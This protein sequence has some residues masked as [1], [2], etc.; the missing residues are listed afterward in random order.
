M[1]FEMS[2]V[3]PLLTEKQIDRTERELDVKLPEDYRSFL[4]HTNGGKPQRDFFP[5]ES[6][7]TLQTGRLVSL[8]GLG[9][10]IKQSNIDWNY[11]NLI[12]QLPN[13]HFPIGITPEEDMVTLSLGRLDAGRIYYWVRAEYNVSGDNEAYFIANNFSKFVDKLYALS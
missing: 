10:P 8:F 9:R 13:Y 4:L 6:H 5:I 3:G 12:G 2:D 11:K 1:S 7:K